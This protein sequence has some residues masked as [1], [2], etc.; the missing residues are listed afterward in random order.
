[1]K[2]PERI[3]ADEE[4]ASVNDRREHEGAVAGG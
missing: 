2:Q 1:M 3:L 4:T